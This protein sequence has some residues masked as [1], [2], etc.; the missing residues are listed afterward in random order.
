MSLIDEVLEFFFSGNI[1][2]FYGLWKIME[3]RWN[4]IAVFIVFERGIIIP[5]DWG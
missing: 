5:G 1:D 4:K 2:D 3:F